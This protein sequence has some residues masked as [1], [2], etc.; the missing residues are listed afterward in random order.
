MHQQ[1]NQ[2]VFFCQYKLL[3]ANFITSQKVLS[4]IIILKIDSIE[5]VSLHDNSNIK[6]IDE[7]KCNPTGY[8]KNEDQDICIHSDSLDVEKADGVKRRRCN[9][10]REQ[11]WA[12][13][14]SHICHPVNDKCFTVVR[15]NGEMFIVSLKPYDAT[16]E[17]QKWKWNE[18][19]SQIESNIKMKKGWLPL[20]MEVTT[21]AFDDFGYPYFESLECDQNKWSQK[22]NF[23]PITDANNHQVCAE[24]D[25][26]GRTHHHGA[27]ANKT[28]KKL[29]YVILIILIFVF[30]KLNLGSN[31]EERLKSAIKVGKTKLQRNIN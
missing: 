7:S 28:E 16:A 24:F 22:W 29:K 2:T 27:V 26:R 4:S 31:K 6:K 13:N 10:G 11:Q 12:I 15:N 17:A 5:G 30:L 18:E 20:C 23:T 14:G 1:V 8:L 25:E 19:T 9:D 21:R 3:Y